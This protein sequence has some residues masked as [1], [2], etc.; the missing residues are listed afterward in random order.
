MISIITKKS[1]KRLIIYIFLWIS[2][3]LFISG[4]AD[5][6][7]ES[8]CEDPI[9]ES[10]LGLQ[11]FSKG[12]LG[13]HLA[14]DFEAPA[15][16]EVRAIADGHMEHNYTKMRYY[17]GCDGKPG[18]VLITRHSGGSNG[19]YAVQYGHVI[20]NL[21]ENDL[22][23]AGDVIGKVINYIPCCDFPEGCPH[24]HFAIW[25]APTEHPT[26]GMGYGKPRSFVNPVWFFENNLCTAGTVE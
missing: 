18:P 21:K 12:L 20:S 13:Q 17:G 25:D 2:F 6:K 10:N 11:W 1:K 15:G 3:I 9:E 22:I 16:T 8:M 24:L 7:V 4:C 5:N 14:I 26:S 19:S 23:F